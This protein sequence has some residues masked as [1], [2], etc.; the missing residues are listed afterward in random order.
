ML[1]RGLMTALIFFASG[2]ILALIIKVAY[3]NMTPGYYAEYGC[4]GYGYLTQAQ[5]EK[6]KMKINICPTVVCTIKDD[7]GYKIH[8]LFNKI[9]FNK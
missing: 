9:D 4:C 6:E 5:I 2:L 3:I 1:L 7:P 8:V